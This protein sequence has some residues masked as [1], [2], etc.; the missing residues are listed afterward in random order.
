[1]QS[2]IAM[3]RLSYLRLALVLV[4]TINDGWSVCSAK[5]IVPELHLAVSSPPGGY[6][7]GY[8][9]ASLEPSLKWSTEG[10]ML[11]G[12]CDFSGG[13]EIT[14]P[15]FD[16]G[17]DQSVLPFSVW[18]ILRK[19]ISG[20][21]LKAKL[22]AASRNLNDV[23][24]DVQAVGGPTNVVLRAIGNIQ[25]N[26]RSIGS[27]KAAIRNVGL[28][29]VFRVPFGNLVWSPSYDLTSGQ[30]KIKAS[31]E[32]SRT[33]LF[34][35]AHQGQ[36]SIALKYKIDSANAIIPSIT[37]DGEVSLEYHHDVRDAGI[38]TAVYHPN[39]EVTIAYE[40]GPWTASASLPIDGYYKLYAKPSFVIRRSLTAE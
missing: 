33:H 31:Y 17:T 1:M 15:N 12:F 10:S 4:V 35:D 3:F 6:S 19:G 36:Q 9:T 38:F 23:N 29:Q 37:S 14:R 32:T 8:A 2:I 11:G 16:D 18:G 7:K 28:T 24:F 30:P 40:D 39:E 26:T 13:V 27:L 22:N 5:G 34:I 20:W 21:D 25:S